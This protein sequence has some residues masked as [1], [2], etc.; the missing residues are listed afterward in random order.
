[1]HLRD[2]TIEKFRTYAN[3]ISR[4]VIFIERKLVR[5]QGGRIENM[6]IRW[7]ERARQAGLN[8]TC[9]SKRR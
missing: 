1:M 3:S 2:E 7:E 8:G 9:V 4:V 6:V 5:K